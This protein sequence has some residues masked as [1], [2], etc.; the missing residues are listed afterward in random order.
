MKLYEAKELALDDKL[1]EFVFDKKYPKDLLSITYKLLTKVF[2][3][4]HAF[5]HCSEITTSPKKYFECSL[6]I[7]SLE[8]DSLICLEIDATLEDKS[9]KNYQ[10]T[11]S[12]NEDSHLLGNKLE[13]Q[14]KNKLKIL[15]TADNVKNF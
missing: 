1:K 7:V 11:K 10:F 3:I 4:K 2:A 12:F 9:V 8:N 14:F 5:I 15:R 6:L 13:M